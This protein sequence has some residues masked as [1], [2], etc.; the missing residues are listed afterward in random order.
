V[1]DRQTLRHVA[2]G[3][4]VATFF[5]LIALGA[6]FIRAPYATAQDADRAAIAL[7][8]GLAV[9]VVLAA[10]GHAPLRTK[11]LGLGAVVAATLLFALPVF[12]LLR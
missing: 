3:A 4:T 7:A 8:V 12:V 5:G 9:G 10:S 2:L 6:A 1:V 11:L